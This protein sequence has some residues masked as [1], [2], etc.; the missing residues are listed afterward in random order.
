MQMVRKVPPRM[1]PF[2]SV[3]IAYSGKDE[4][5][6]YQVRP[7]LV[8]TQEPSYVSEAF[9]EA[10]SARLN[11]FDIASVYLHLELVGAYM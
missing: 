11:A 5:M 4:D 3:S 1:L 6:L 9:W 8:T 7:G 2:I 10:A